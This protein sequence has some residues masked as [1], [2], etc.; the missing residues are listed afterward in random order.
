MWTVPKQEKC[1]K[2]VGSITSL[3]VACYPSFFSFANVY[4]RFLSKSRGWGAAIVIVFLFSAL[5]Q[6]FT[7]TKR[8]GIDW[9]P[10]YY[11]TGF[12]DPGLHTPREP[13]HGIFQQLLQGVFSSAPA[14][15]GNLSSRQGSIIHLDLVAQRAVHHKTN[16]LIMTIYYWWYH[17]DGETLWLI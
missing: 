10:S 12:Q 16:A 2:N 17:S 1:L 13:G 8:L 6:G 4:F 5:S 3:D 7:L 15:P 14:L 9:T 11:F